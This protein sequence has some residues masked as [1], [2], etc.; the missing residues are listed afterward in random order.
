[1][2]D[3]E[4]MDHAEAV[5]RSIE[6]TC[7]RINDATDADIDNQRVGGMV[8]LSF[9]SGS[10]IVV[11]LQKPLQEIWMAAR[12]GGYHYKFDGSVWRDTKTGNEFFA[13]LTE[14]ATAQ[15]GRALQFQA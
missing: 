11:N 4:Y 3:P 9:A 1:M 2:T 8:T 14:Q 5:L 7:D 13:D 12:A 10:Q 6:A 15:G